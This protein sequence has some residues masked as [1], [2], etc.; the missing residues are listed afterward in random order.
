MTIQLS[1]KYP[2]QNLPFHPLACVAKKGINIFQS[3]A[4]IW[5]VVQTLIYTYESD[6]NCLNLA[7]TKP[8]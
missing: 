8:D 5:H 3:K 6:A 2:T 1:K 7:N 4:E